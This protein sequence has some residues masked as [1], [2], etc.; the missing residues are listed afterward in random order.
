MPRRK[1]KF[2]S[3]TFSH[4]D[5]FK[6][7]VQEIE[8]IEN[9]LKSIIGHDV[10]QQYLRL[11]INIIA[12]MRAKI[13]MARTMATPQESVAEIKIVIQKVK[14]I[15]NLLSAGRISQHTHLAI[16][17]TG[18]FDG[19]YEEMSNFY[20]LLE[21]VEKY[22]LNAQGRLEQNKN[23]S[24]N[25]NTFRTMMIKDLAWAHENIFFLKP[26]KYRNG[27]FEKIA[28]L[29]LK[30][31]PHK[32]KNIRMSMPENLFILIKDAIDQNTKDPVEPLF[33]NS[34]YE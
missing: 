11:F 10:P 30:S 16:M 29:F 26:T 20:F 33:E 21:K 34:F 27:Q 18:M 6:P 12:H 25:V 9:S 2:S 8:N 14:D 28:R 22:L 7:S 23:K 17:Q 31:V 24:S 13:N 5:D 1:G 19:S 32:E 15:Q 4:A 3:A